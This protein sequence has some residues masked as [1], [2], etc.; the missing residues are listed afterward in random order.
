MS[1]DDEIDDEHYRKLSAN[2]RVIRRSHTT[3]EDVLEMRRLYWHEGWT[4]KR[5]RE[6]FG[7][8]KSQTHKIVKGQ[9]WVHVW[10]KEDY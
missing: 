4:E 2:R 6:K 8:S 10:P 1:W 7:M 9:V 3:E 5:I